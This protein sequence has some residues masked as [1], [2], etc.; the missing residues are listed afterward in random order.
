[1]VFVRLYQRVSQ[2]YEVAL[3]QYQ[4][5]VAAGLQPSTR[6]V[7]LYSVGTEEGL[8]VCANFLYLGLVVLLYL[9]MLRRKE[10]VR[11][12]ALMLGYNTLNVCISLFVACS[13]LFFKVSSRGFNGEGRDG[14]VVSPGG[15][16]GVGGF[17]CNPLRTDLQGQMV[18]R[19]F[20]VFY[21]QKY[22]EL[23]DTFLFLLRRSFRQVTFFHLFHHCSITVIVGSILPFD[24]N[25]DM[26]LPIMLNSIVHVLVYLHYVLSAL[27]KHSWWSRHLTKL[28]LTQFAVILV[29]SA[30][31]F[32]R[33]PDCGSPD[34][35]K[36]VLLLYMISLLGLFALFF[37]K[38]SLLG[39]AEDPGMCGVIKSL[40]A[41]SSG[42][43]GGTAGKTEGVVA[44]PAAAAAGSWHGNVLLDEVGAAEIWL[45][46]GFPAETLAG[47]TTYSYQLTPVGAPMPGL[48]VSEEIATATSR[49]S[50]P[51]SRLRG[52][53]NDA[54]SCISFSVKG[55][56]PR[57]TVSWAVTAV[58]APCGGGG[59]GTGGKQP[60]SPSH[61]SSE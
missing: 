38:R 5:R 37:V 33:G 34:F 42:G 47:S 43:I 29:Q 9:R 46:P 13:L 22:L 1:M 55:G 35:V 2:S 19:V 59:G 36:V 10:P 11:L 16:G 27:G 20:A 12:R 6:V 21:L 45:P 57:F 56:K 60:L 51:I 61:K 49:G 41:D 8:L 50:K 30:T 17:V 40:E 28:Q 58:G 53:S 23:V 52:D 54:G 48:F 14:S 7:N 3:G 18:A 26:Y 44:A 15:G 32:Y 31:A 25:G 39:P 4:D 24:F